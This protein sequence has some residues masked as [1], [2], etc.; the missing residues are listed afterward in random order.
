MTGLIDAVKQAVQG[1]KPDGAAPGKPNLSLV[2]KGAQQPEQGG[3]A[4]QMLAS[5]EQNV[6]RLVPESIKRA[7]RAIV[8]AGRELM[9][10]EQ[11]HQEMVS[12]MATIKS[13]QEVPQKVAHGIVKTISI[14]ANEVT[15]KQKQFS[16]PAAGAAAMTLMTYALKYVDGALNIP[17]T[18]EMIDQTTIAIDK[19]MLALFGEDQNKVQAA[20]Q[21]AA[22]R[23]QQEQPGAEPEKMAPKRSDGTIG[24]EEVE[25]EE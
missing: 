21:H 22:Q 3:G 4:A 13:P 2:P 11:T 6:E 16:R 19:G 24:D 1:G 18:P 14:I 25:E 17:V 12:Y 10:S 7:Y 8:L 5:I 15:K 9:F 23:G 20:M